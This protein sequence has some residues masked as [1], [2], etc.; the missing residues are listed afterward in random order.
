MSGI[1][2]IVDAATMS[3][4]PTASCPMM[5]SPRGRVMCV[6]SVPTAVV[7]MSPV[8]VGSVTAMPVPTM[9]AAGEGRNLDGQTDD[10]RQSNQV[11]T[12]HD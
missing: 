9:S 3:E 1:V 2:P 11:Q 8:A 10:R 6:R 5:D 7:P 4:G 12:S